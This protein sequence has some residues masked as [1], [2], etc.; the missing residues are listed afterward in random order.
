[1]PTHD[2]YALNRFIRAQEPVFES[3]LAE[4]RAGR[5]RTHW[6]WYVF[7]QIEGLGF[8]SISRYYSIKSE[9]E[10]RQYLNHPILGARLVKCAEILLYLEGV[11]A[12]DIF[13]YPDFMKL[14]SSM[15]LF[16]AVAEPGS[17]FERV[18]DKYY[19]GERDQKTLSLAGL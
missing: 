9:A 17:V 15:T 7:P 19:G 11:S 2:P 18:L 4:L 14:R 8:S 13:G 10:A 16:A 1:M 6:M 5:K 3:V 12:E